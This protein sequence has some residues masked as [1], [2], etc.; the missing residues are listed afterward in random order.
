MT[1]PTWQQARHASF[2]RLCFSVDDLLGS[3]ANI[4]CLA[5]NLDKLVNISFSSQLLQTE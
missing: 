3:E 5:E 4:K 1:S 2:T